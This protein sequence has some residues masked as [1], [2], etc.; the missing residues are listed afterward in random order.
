MYYDGLE[1]RTVAKEIIGYS[2]A[3][4]IVHGEASST[5]KQHERICWFSTQNQRQ[6]DQQ[7]ILHSSRDNKK[8]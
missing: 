7:S 6:N 3:E 4:V 8:I 2:S 5:V 1:T